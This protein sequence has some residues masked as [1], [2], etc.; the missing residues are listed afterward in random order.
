M[1]FGEYLLFWG[2]LHPEGGE[3]CQHQVGQG[4]RGLRDRGDLNSLSPWWHLHHLHIH[5]GFK[6]LYTYFR[7]SSKVHRPHFLDHKTISTCQMLL[8]NPHGSRNTAYPA[9]PFIIKFSS[10]AWSEWNSRSSRKFSGSLLSWEIMGHH[11][12]TLTFV[13]LSG[14]KLIATAPNM[15]H[16]PTNK[17]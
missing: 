7:T 5:Y 15:S 11:I 12:P 9:N 17:N 14:Y 10:A 4:R 2:R 16:T 13:Q 8:C 1:S 6:D 3:K